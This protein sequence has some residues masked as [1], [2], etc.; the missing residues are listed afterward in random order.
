[1]QIAT[2]EPKQAVAQEMTSPKSAIISSAGTYQSCWSIVSAVGMIHSRKPPPA[3]ATHRAQRKLDAALGELEADDADAF[4]K[5][6]R[7]LGDF[8][9]TALGAAALKRAKPAR[10]EESLASL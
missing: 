9:D 2:S 7:S 8:G 5:M 1:M 4:D 6:V 10:G 3:A